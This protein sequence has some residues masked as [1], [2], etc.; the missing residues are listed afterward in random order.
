MIAFFSLKRDVKKFRLQIKIYLV[1][2]LLNSSEERLEVL[3]ND[4]ADVIEAEPGIEERAESLH[5]FELHSFLHRLYL[6]YVLKVDE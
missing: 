4:V 6:S 3:M 2:F 5:E 1:N